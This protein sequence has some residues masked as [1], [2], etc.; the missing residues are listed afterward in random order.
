MAFAIN[1]QPLPLLWPGRPFPRQL[2][3][4]RPGLI[5]KW[6]STD[7]LHPDPTVLHPKITPVSCCLVEF[8]H[9]PVL[10]TLG[11]TSVS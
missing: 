9:L 11:P 5:S 10:L 6:R 2:S 1:H 7:E 4:K 3:S 8:T